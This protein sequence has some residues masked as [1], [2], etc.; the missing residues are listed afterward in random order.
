M[1]NFINLFE[2]ELWTNL[3]Y[4]LIPFD[5]QKPVFIYKTQRISV[6]EIF[7]FIPHTKYIYI[8]N[9]HVNIKFE[10]E[11]LI[12]IYNNDFITRRVWFTIRMLQ[13]YVTNGQ[14]VLTF[15]SE[16]FHRDC[17]SDF[18][19]K[20]LKYSQ[21]WRG[22]SGSERDVLTL[23]CAVP[24]TDKL[25]FLLQRK[26]RFRFIYACESTS[27]ESLTLSSRSSSV[28]ND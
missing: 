16:A 20:G 15:I 23:G 5:L 27:V 8:P 19:K 2:L 18:T 9:S 4:I 3:E 10:R 7:T 12:Y 14:A 6:C 17:E 28:E 13:A 1:S 24:T 22:G 11:I 26:I 25:L 21:G